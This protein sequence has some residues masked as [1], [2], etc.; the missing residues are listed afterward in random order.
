MTTF[1]EREQAFESKFAHDA[2]L[3]FKVEARA[4][5]LLALWAANQLDRHGEAAVDYAKALIT[6]WIEGRGPSDPVDRVMA[7][8]TPARPEIGRAEAA[9][10]LSE[11]RV[12]AKKQ[13]MEES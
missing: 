6:E 10:K 7:D 2:E 12:Q 11:L 13:V 8:L 3:Q 9:R 5:N 1:D 4:R